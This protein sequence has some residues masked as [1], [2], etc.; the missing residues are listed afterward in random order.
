MTAQT[1]DGRATAAAVKEEL[2]ARVAA[3]AERGLT[4][5]L[6]TVL[7]GEDPGSQKYVA[8]KHRDC[9]EVGIRS[10]QKELPADATEE[11]VLAVVHE[12]NEDPECTGYIVQL[13]LPEHVDTQRVLEAIDPDKDADGLHP[14]NLGRLV[15]LSLIHI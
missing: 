8:G 5:G 11:Q 6:G 13:P 14:M 2:H 1:L 3:L 7:V 9:A 12:L 15:A 4:P 10:I